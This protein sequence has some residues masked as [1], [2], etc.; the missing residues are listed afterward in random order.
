MKAKNAN[1]AT[2]NMLRIVENNHFRLSDMADNKAHLMVIVCSLMLPLLVQRLHDAQLRHS[3]IIM[4]VA[5]VVSI[6]CALYSA[7]PT[8]HRR[9]AGKPRVKN[10]NF[11]IL[12]FGN[13]TQLTYEEFESEMER[14]IND[15]DLVYEALLRDLYALGE[16]LNDKK[17][18][19]VRWSYVSFMVGLLISGIALG[20]S[21]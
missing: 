19:F 8:Y 15:R 17:Y 18:R 5:C 20:F 7:M 12:F 21:W 11:N 13:F 6:L 4:M 10:P 16:V 1:R 9:Q 3:V 14:V 2:D